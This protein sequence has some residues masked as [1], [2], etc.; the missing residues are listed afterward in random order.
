F[1]SLTS[2][3]SEARSKSHSEHHSSSDHEASATSA[4]ASGAGHSTSSAADSSSTLDPALAAGG[5]VSSTSAAPTQEK[6][7]STGSMTPGGKAGLAIGIIAIL[8]VILGAC[9]FMYRRRRAS[10]AD[11]HQRLDDEKGQLHRAN[12]NAFPMMAAAPVPAMS[13][14]HSGRA[15]ST[16]PRL[17]LRPVTQFFGMN[18]NRKSAGN[19]LD[20]AT[21]RPTTAGTASAG[22]AA[23]APT[24][25]RAPGAS[26]P[27]AAAAAA[28]PA[29]SSAW[30]KMGQRDHATDPNNPFGIHAETLKVSPPASEIA[31]APSSPT[32]TDAPAMAAGA[33]AGAAAVAGLAA[34]SASEKE[35]SQKDLSIVPKPL[36]VKSSKSTMADGPKSPAL[37]EASEAPSSFAAAGAVAA[38]PSGPNNVH[39]VQLDFNPSMDDELD[40]KAG[41]LVRLLHEYDDGWVS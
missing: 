35:S 8:A 25:L 17:S 29:S 15:N 13:R 2:S 24:G 7:A 12:T 28:A 6:S 10:Q 40:L 19:P 27:A 39:R 41:Q 1:P 36:S 30:E 14:A 11:E 20:A 4:S 38:A 3:S 5:S 32:H 37:S 22:A 9:V 18:P 31:T 34:A 16:A 23:G 26:A 21:S 33:A